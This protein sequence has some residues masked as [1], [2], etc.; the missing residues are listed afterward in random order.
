MYVEA[1]RYPVGGRD[2][3]DGLAVAAGLVLVGLLVVRFARGL[4]PSVLA[5]PVLVALVPPAVVFAAQVGTAL[6]TSADGDPRPPRVDLSVETPRVGARVMAATVGYLVVPAALLA[7][8]GV[9]IGSL[10]GG[11]GPLVGIGSTVALLGCAAFAYALPVGVATT[12]REGLAR[13]LRIRSLEG[14]SSGAYFAAW[15]GGVV[16]V[17]AG[18][19]VVRAVEP[20]TLPAVIAV[21]GFAYAHLAAARLVGEGV[22]R[23]TGRSRPGT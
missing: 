2:A 6:S 10:A 4:W 17:V 20:A 14:L 21:V 5:V 11:G 1:L 8:V 12:L 7:A 15:I 16:L 18:W 22:A 23:A 3:V 13:G 9:G 19:L